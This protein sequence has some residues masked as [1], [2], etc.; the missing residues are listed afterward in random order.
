MTPIPGGND[1]YSTGNGTPVDRCGT[2]RLLHALN[3]LDGGDLLPGFRC[4]VRDL[5][6]CTLSS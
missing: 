4:P 6:K 2:L 1:G 3:E 5:F